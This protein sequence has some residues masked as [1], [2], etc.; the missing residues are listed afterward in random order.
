MTEKDILNKIKESADSV[1][2]PDSLNPEQIEL[3]LKEQKPPKFKW[4]AMHLVAAAVAL[5]MMLGIIPIGLAWRGDANQS[6]AANVNVAGKDTIA[7]LMVEEQQDATALKMEEE[8]LAIEKQDAGELYLVAK[9]YDDVY[10][11]MKNN[12]EMYSRYYYT[13]DINYGEVME[14]AEVEAGFDGSIKNDAIVKDFAAD[15]AVV[16]SKP[17][18][19][20]A[21]GNT[22]AHKQGYSTTNLQMAGVDESDIVKTNGTHI[23]VVKDGVVQVVKLDNGQMTQVGTISPDLESFSDNVLEM[24]VDEDRLILITQQVKESLESMKTESMKGGLLPLTGDTA[25]VCVDMVY[26]FDAS[27]NTVLYTYDIS[28]PANAKQIGKVEQDGFYKTSRKIDNMVYLFTQDNITVDKGVLPESEDELADLLP[29]VNGEAIA[30][31]CIYL[32]EYG[33]QALVVSSV[34]MDK[35]D[36]VVDNTLIMNDYVEI[37]VS[38]NAMYLYNAQYLGENPLTQIAKFDLKN[39]YISAVAAATVPG[40]VQD[41]F[42]VN[43]YNDN[44]R[45]LTSHWDVSISDRTNQLYILDSKLKTAG[46]IENIAEGETIYAARYFGDLVYFITYRNIDPLFAA[47]LSDINNPKILGELKIT[48]YSEYLHMWSEDKLLGI[49]YETDEKDGSREGIKLAMFDISNPAELSIIDTVVIKTADYSPA[50][51]NYKSVLADTFTNMIGFVTADYNEDELEYRMYSF[52]N[53]KFQEKLVVEKENLKYQESYRGLWAGNYFYV[54]NPAEI[55]SFDYT[56][57]YE[58]VDEMDF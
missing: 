23:F 32:P 4:Q 22:S 33:Y 1:E 28:N 42:A 51:F 29:K 43:E 17:T 56:K 36:E 5:V 30:Y 58:A 10:E 26:N 39:G 15:G 48:G 57:N 8:V 47:D 50:L 46:K 53:G 55:Q 2:I 49:G 7:D 3:M 11:F 27:Y 34:S 24:Y 54:V 25:E 45:I 35:P 20:S 37:Y 31:D 19:E 16:E 41:T 18:A 40:T 44:L 38:S 12:V 13:D 14:E 52:V 9:S 6:D 21:L